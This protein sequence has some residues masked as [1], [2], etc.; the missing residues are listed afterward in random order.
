MP[1]LYYHI[2]VVGL[3]KDVTIKVSFLQILITEKLGRFNKIQIPLK[4]A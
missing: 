4:R 3:G 2:Q 1:D